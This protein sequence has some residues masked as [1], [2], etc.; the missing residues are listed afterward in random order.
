LGIDIQQASNRELAAPCPVP[1][2][3]TYCE[4]TA[5]SALAN[6]PSRHCRVLKSNDSMLRMLGFL[7]Q[8]GVARLVADPMLVTVSG[9][10]ATFRQGG[11]V[12]VRVSA[13]DA[14]A[15]IEMRPVG[16]E[17]QVLPE[18]RSDG[19]LRLEL[20]LNVSVLAPGQNVTD[21]DQARPA[22]NM[23]E[24]VT[25]I[26]LESG[27]TLAL[28]EFKTPAKE[29]GADVDTLVLVTAS[30]FEESEQTQP[31]PRQLPAASRASQPRTSR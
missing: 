1:D 14:E 18:I 28:G 9:R 22:F 7:Q 29:N 6:Q 13:P 15:A 3:K 12:P 20:R 24:I 2:I 25:G 26:E 10:S 31:D 16:T 27:Q 5:A 23:R 30:I 17:L 8:R 19:K 21:K 4:V 11:D